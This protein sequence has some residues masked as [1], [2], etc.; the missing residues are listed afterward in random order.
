MFLQI[1]QLSLSVMYLTDAYGH[2][3]L[4]E[5]E[6]NYH[7]YFPKLLFPTIK[8]ESPHLLREKTDLMVRRYFG[9]TKISENPFAFA[10]VSLKKKRIA[11][12]K[13]SNIFKFFVF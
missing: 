2:D 6:K 10:Q 13:P 12:S 4:Q 11:E 7:K 1:L 8:Q 9:N 5:L 3:A